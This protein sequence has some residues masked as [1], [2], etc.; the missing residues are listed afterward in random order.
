MINEIV[1]RTKIRNCVLA[2]FGED[3]DASILVLQTV[4]KPS[5]FDRPVYLAVISL[6]A[7][8]K[9]VVAT[10]SDCDPDEI[11]RLQKHFNPDY[12]PRRFF[13]I[14]SQLSVNL[15]LLRSDS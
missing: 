2:E 1:L 6:K 3:F 5:R 8:E 11:E 10:L 9:D 12:S 14:R 7:L 13:G 15:E 4:E